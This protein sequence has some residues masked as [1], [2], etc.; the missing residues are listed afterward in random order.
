MNQTN[1]RESFEKYM[2]FQISRKFSLLLFCFILSMSAFSQ[3][4][5]FLY[6]GQKLLLV[7]PTPPNGGALYK[8]AWAAIGADLQVSPSNT[9][10]YVTVTNFFEGIQ[11]IQCDYYW[12]WYDRNFVQH[13][14]HATTFYNINCK[15]VTL[16]PS[17]NSL[18]LKIGE[19]KQ[20]SY[21]YRPSNV[22]PKPTVRY[23][24]NNTNVCTVT[25]NGYVTGVGIGKATI[26]LEN[27]SGP[28]ELCEIQVGS[29]DPTGISIPDTATLY[30]G[31]QAPIKTSFYPSDA[32]S[33]ITWYCNPETVAT[34]SNGIVMGKDEGEAVAYCVTKNN[35]K[36]NACKLTVIYRTATG[37]KYE[38]PEASVPIGG[39]IFLS[40]SITPTNAKAKVTLKSEDETIATVMPSGEVFGIKEGTTRI[41]VSTDNGCFAS[42]EVSVRPNPTSIEL[43][44]Q[45]PIFVNMGVPMAYKVTPQN[46]HVDLKWTSSSSDVATIDKN[47]GESVVTVETHNNIKASSR[48]VVVEPVLFLS[49]QMKNGDNVSIPFV[50]HPTI[51][52]NASFFI[53]NSTDRRIEVPTEQVSVIS[54]GGYKIQKPSAIEPVIDRRSNTIIGEDTEPNLYVFIYDVS[55]NLVNRIKT[56]DDDKISWHLN[57]LPQGTYIIK[58]GH[59]SLKFIKK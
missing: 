20:L 49:I 9:S 46:A 6:V 24:S 27:S 32:I 44:D 2:K 1:S 33:D 41:T 26:K 35:V 13:T 10:A 21:T 54:I 23:I 38:K 12:Y 37:I 17:E 58:K 22:D 43:L 31:E 51:E 18:I 55:G 7:A 25:N 34:I 57:S 40:Y 4:S 19:T 53:V 36:S 29:K 5:N 42:C 59:S 28:S 39:S 16:V 30:V 52:T 56:G 50:D 14:N 11:Q 48:I 45:E 3:S 15:A 8:T 47:L